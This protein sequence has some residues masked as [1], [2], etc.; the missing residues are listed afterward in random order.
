MIIQWLCADPLIIPGLTSYVL[1]HLQ[2]LICGEPCDTTKPQVIGPLP[3]HTT[4]TFEELPTEII[5]DIVSFL[6]A[7]PALRLRRCSRTFYTKMCLDR[8]FWLHHLVSG[9]LVDY[10]WD[11]D[12]EEI[13]QKHKIGSWNWKQLAQVLFHA[14]LIESALAKSLRGEVDMWTSAFEKAN[15]H[16]T[17]FRDA[18]I[19]L[20]N[21]C[22]MIRIVRD[23]ERIEEAE[24]KDNSQRPSPLDGKMYGALAEIT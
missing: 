21:R 23:I 9:D 8:K 17:E 1:S 6:P 18:P 4:T 3:I 19:R 13:N 24:A 15:M 20:Q 11:L 14:E 5:N 7:I 16:K 12:V 22:R 2:P 10:L